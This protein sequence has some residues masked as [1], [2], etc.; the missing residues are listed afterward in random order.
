MARS[1]AFQSDCATLFRI[2]AACPDRAYPVPLPALA[3]DLLLCGRWFMKTS[4]STSFLV[5]PFFLLCL[6][7]VKRIQ[8]RGIL[9]SISLYQRSMPPAYDF[10]HC[11]PCSSH[12]SAT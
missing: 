2:T 3:R 1:L 9:G 5:L 12:H 7:N 4:D 10:A 11:P 8:E 6:T